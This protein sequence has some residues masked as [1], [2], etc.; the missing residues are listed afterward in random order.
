M[1]S[2]LSY[3]LLSPKI[4]ELTAANVG[5]GPNFHILLQLLGCTPKNKAL[6]PCVDWFARYL[7][8]RLY[9]IDI[10]I[11]RVGTKEVI[12]R[13][14]RSL[15]RFCEILA[16]VVVLLAD[17]EHISI[18]EIIEGLQQKQLIPADDGALAIQQQL[19]FYLLGCITMLYDPDPKPKEG[20]LKLILP[21]CSRD[22]TARSETWRYI[23]QEVE[24][25]SGSVG[26]LLRRFGGMK[27][28]IPRP[29]L[30][31]IDNTAHSPSNIT[32]QCT[33]LCYYTLTRLAKVEIIWVND[34]C[35]HLEFDRRQKTLKLF[36]CPSFCILLLLHNNGSSFLDRY[37][38]SK[39]SRLINKLNNRYQLSQ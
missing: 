12:I 3:S 27:G 29:D 14:S 11:L 25:V 19:I 38:S 26:D 18:S 9:K 32:L 33:N 24:G 37:V 35:L 30:I 16:T 4:A 8:Y 13:D 5:A 2:F 39:V 36:R 1:K 6:T 31:D 17:H 34:V 28:P 21:R 7:K 23:S 15:E 10:N 20:V 22:R